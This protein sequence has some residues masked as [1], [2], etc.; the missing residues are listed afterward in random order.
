MRLGLVLLFAPLV[1]IGAC[2]GD[3]F[4]DD[5]G[6]DSGSDGVIVGGDGAVDAP[7][8]APAEGAAK[9]F[10][11]TVDAQF[12]ADFDIPNDAGAGFFPSM[13]TNGYTLT[14]QS[15]QFKS[16]PV[17]VEAFI[18][19]DASGMADM[20][21]IVY[22]ADA[23]TPASITL[24]MDMYVPNLSTSTTQPLFLFLFGVVTSQFQ[25]GL[26]HDGPVWK[27]EYVPTK[28]GPALNVPFALNEW[29]HLTL[30]IVLSSTAGS[31][32]LTI[33]S[34]AGTSVAA[35]SPGQ[36]ATAP[37]STGPYPIVVDVGPRSSVPPIVSA[38]AYYDN[39]VVRVQ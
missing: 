13:T 4:D 2:N 26:A 32:T 17:G 5:G 30:A 18:P 1:A 31:A 36:F 25:F 28:Q 10:C 35:T 22:Q 12:C 37:A 34:S 24:D 8:D 6:V 39:V 7:V 19:A 33:T 21:T 23:G 15:N 27:L 14:F 38:Q 11:E 3:S 9:R 16:A 20:Q 29:L